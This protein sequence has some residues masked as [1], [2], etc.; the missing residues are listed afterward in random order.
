MWIPDQMPLENDEIGSMG[1][2]ELAMLRRFVKGV[3]QG[4][5]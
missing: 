1:T 3:L 4:E 5:A 2:V